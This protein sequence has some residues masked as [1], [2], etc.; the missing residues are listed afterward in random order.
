MYMY[1]VLMKMPADIAL[2]VDKVYSQSM[3]V[4]G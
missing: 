2:N 3:A 1:M 4:F